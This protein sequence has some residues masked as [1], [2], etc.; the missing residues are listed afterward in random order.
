[1]NLPDHVYDRDG[2]SV[3]RT[4]FQKKDLEGAK[5]LHKECQP[6]VEFKFTVNDPAKFEK[7]GKK[8][9]LADWFKKKPAVGS[10]GLDFNT[11]RRP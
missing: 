3:R 4:R 8:K 11:R 5:K 10:T 2:K 7:K 1:L 6:Y 9:S